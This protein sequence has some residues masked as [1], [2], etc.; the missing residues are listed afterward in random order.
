MK[1]YIDHDINSIQNFFTPDIHDNYQMLDVNVYQE[2]IFHTK[3][4]QKDL[5][6]NTYLFGT[7]KEELP[8]ADV[9]EMT[10][11]LHKE[12]NEIFYGRN[13]PDMTQYNT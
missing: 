13:M 8:E 2:N 1:H 5:D 9:K 11:R 10:E 7:T 6:L 4:M 3:M 12:M